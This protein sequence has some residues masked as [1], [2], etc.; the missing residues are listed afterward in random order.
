[1]CFAVRFI[2]FVCC[3]NIWNICDITHYFNVGGEIFINVL[4]NAIHGVDCVDRLLTKA[5]K[6]LH[7][8]GSRICD[9]RNLVSVQMNLEARV[10]NVVRL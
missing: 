6:V 5:L 2:L 4:I 10:G 9:F 7:Y 8:F 1:M 3:Q